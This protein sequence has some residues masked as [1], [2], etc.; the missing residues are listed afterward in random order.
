MK[1][2]GWEKGKYFFHSLGSYDSYPLFITDLPE[3]LGIGLEKDGHVGRLLDVR[4]NC[5]NF[6]GEAFNTKYC[7]RNA[8]NIFL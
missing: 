6:Q 5:W 1:V 7:L 8:R 4:K 3:I 2:V